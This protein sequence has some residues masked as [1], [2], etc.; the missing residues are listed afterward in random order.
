MEKHVCKGTVLQQWG[1]SVFV[2]GLSSTYYR[3]VWWLR[4]M[5]TMF[6]FVSYVNQDMN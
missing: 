3:I 5:R 2:D 4:N 6:G 1:H